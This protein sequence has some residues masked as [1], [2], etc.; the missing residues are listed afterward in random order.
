M[1]FELP[2][3][4]GIGD[5]ITYA[6]KAALA[7]VHTMLPGQVIVYDPATQTAEIQPTIQ[8]RRRDDTVPTG[9]VP[10]PCPPI[11]GVPVVWPSTVTAGLTFPL[12]PSTV[13]MLVFA[14][15]SLDEYLSTGNLASIPLDL[16]RHNMQDAY[17]IP[18]GRPQTLPI[19]PAGYDATATVLRGLSVILGDSV[20]GFHPVL[21]GDTF[22]ANLLTFLTAFEIYVTGVSTATTAAQIA[23]LAAT[24]LPSV[25]AFK[26][27][28][29]SGIHQSLIVKTS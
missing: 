11:G 7:D 18:G 24:L 9:H 21:H 16:R 3:D 26:S 28:V 8:G 15:R 10:V 5:L 13:G 25:T 17:F 1:P 4:P 20:T 29:S 12:P 14:E 27:L 23:G 19:D 22:E 2:N 6:I